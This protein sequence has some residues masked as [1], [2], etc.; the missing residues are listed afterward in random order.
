M[1]Q[2]AVGVETPPLSDG[3]VEALLELKLGAL[4]DVDDGG[5]LDFGEFEASLDPWARSMQGP[6]GS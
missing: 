2:P 5:V 6:S 3:V 1:Q 4:F